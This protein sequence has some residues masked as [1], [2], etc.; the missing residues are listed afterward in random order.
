MIGVKARIFEKEEK[1]DIVLEAENQTEEE[2]LEN[3]WVSR[4]KVTILSVCRIGKP[5]PSGIFLSLKTK[6]NEN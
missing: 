4:E 3:I 6:G 5:S 1:T 2:Q